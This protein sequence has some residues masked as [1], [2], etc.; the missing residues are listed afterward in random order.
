MRSRSRFCILEPNGAS[1]NHSTAVQT[2]DV[3]GE[4]TPPNGNVHQI[5][6][7]I[8][9]FNM[10]H[11]FNI[12]LIV[13][14]FSTRS[15]ARLGNVVGN[16]L[17]SRIFP[18]FNV[19]VEGLKA[20]ETY[21]FF[22]NLKLKDNNIYTYQDG[23]WIPRGTAK[24]YPSLNQGEFYALRVCLCKC[25]CKCILCKTR[26]DWHLCASLRATRGVQIGII[27]YGS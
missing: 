18:T 16:L 11:L 19:S 24:P 12:L 23:C 4:G 3:A 1:E 2:V 26:P 9:N 21:M 25:L 7:Q 20:D 14:P 10:T 22:L 15:F 5:G 13:V 27:I 6:W 17:C 8:K